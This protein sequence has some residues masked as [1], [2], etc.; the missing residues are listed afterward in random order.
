MCFDFKNMGGTFMQLKVVKAINFNSN[1]RGYF[2]GRI[3]LKKAWLDDMNV[4]PEEPLLELTYDETLK[5]IIVE[6]KK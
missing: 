1:G 4:T 2:L 5:R 3:I 6:K